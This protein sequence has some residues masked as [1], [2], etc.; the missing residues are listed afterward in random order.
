MKFGILLFAITVLLQPISQILQK[1]GMS[2]VGSIDSFGGLLN[3]HTLLSIITNPFVM[4]GIAVSVVNLVLW[5]GVISSMKISY[6]YPFSAI[7]YIILTI[8]AYC[9]LGESIGT[10]KW[11]GMLVIVVGAFILNA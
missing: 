2:L 7:S 4:G 9:V 1:K 5:L 10:V 8:M 6:I 11:F 3:P